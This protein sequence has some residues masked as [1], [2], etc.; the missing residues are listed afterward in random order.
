[1]GEKDDSENEEDIDKRTEK[2]NSN[3]DTRK[4]RYFI[5]K[6]D[7]KTYRKA[8]PFKDSIIKGDEED[9][10]TSDAPRNGGKLEENMS[11]ENILGLKSIYNRVYQG[12]EGLS[13]AAISGF[14][15]LKKTVGKISD[16]MKEMIRV[17]E[18]QD[19]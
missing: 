12:I 13:N 11:Q 2:T 1:M 10:E 18:S 17:E 8:I 5:Y 16:N 15:S 14:L 4:E 9:I 3:V 7:T 19:K 6:K